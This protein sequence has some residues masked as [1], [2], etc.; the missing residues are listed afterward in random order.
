MLYSIRTPQSCPG[1]SYTQDSASC[2]RR[3]RP[4]GPRF[5]VRMQAACWYHCCCTA[6]RVPLCWVVG[7]MHMS[8]C[9]CCCCC[10]C[11]CCCNIQHH[12]RLPSVESSCLPWK[13]KKQLRGIPPWDSI[14]G[15]TLSVPADRR[16]TPLVVLQAQHGCLCQQRSWA[17]IPNPGRPH[18]TTF[19][20]LPLP[21]ITMRM[22]GNTP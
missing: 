17:A 18:R 19:A 6:R 22:K 1:G 3:T 10:C 9:Y 12:W 16:G 14:P 5:V 13:T 21:P 7:R 4:R 15:S 2:H 11:C 20:L 8:G